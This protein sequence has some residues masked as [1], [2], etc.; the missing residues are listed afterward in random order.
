MNDT[1]R[2]SNDAAPATGEAKPAPAKPGAKRPAR[3]PQQQREYDDIQAELRKQNQAA[4]TKDAPR[5]FYKEVRGR[6]HGDVE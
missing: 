5:E 2:T 1:K 3:T 6:V 4:P